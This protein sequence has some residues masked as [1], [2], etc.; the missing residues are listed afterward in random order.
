[1]LKYDV[2][3]G[4]KTKG[5]LNVSVD[6]QFVNSHL[7]LTVDSSFFSW[8]IDTVVSFATALFCFSYV[9]IFYIFGHNY[10]LSVACALG[11]FIIAYLVQLFPI[12]IVGNWICKTVSAIHRIISRFFLCY[13]ALFI[14][15]ILTK[16]YFLV[17]VYLGAWLI[18]ALLELIM[19]KCFMR[20]FTKKYNVQLSPVDYITLKILHSVTRS[21]FSFIDF[22]EQYRYEVE[23]YNYREKEEK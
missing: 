8:L 7:P 15:S 3:R 5:G 16:D 10:I 21:R 17:L 19:G 12:L 14:A 13:I 9:A 20:H 11:V 6:K 2:N 18:R 1:M 4:W 23:E 22:V